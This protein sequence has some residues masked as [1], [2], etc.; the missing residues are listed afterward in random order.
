M[1]SNSFAG[2]SKTWPSKCAWFEERGTTRTASPWRLRPSPIRSPGYRM[3]E[4]AELAVEGRLDF[5]V[6]ENEGIS[7][8]CRRAE[9][10]TGLGG[11]CLEEEKCR[12]GVR[13]E[14]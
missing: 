11:N 4:T 8:L 5:G 2:S 3:S 12:E 10:G 7:I 6:Y 9:R 1:T 14:E 13:G